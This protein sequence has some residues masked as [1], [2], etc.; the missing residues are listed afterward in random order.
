MANTS[1][2]RA[3]KDKNYTV[4]DNTCLRD[5]TLSW[6]ARGIMAYL[7]SLPEDW[8]IY[9]SEVET[10]ATDGRDSLMSGIKELREHGYIVV[11][12][13]R[14]KDGTFENIRYNVIENPNY[15]QTGFPY[16]DKPE[17]VKPVTDNPQLLN[18]DSYQLLNIQNT[19]SIS[20]KSDDKK[21]VPSK[22]EKTDNTTYADIE[23]AYTTAF[24]ELFPDGKCVINYGAARKRIKSLLSTLSEDDII[25]AINKAKSDKW[26][27][28][29]MGFGIMTILSDNQI[30]K[31]LNGNSS[32]PKPAYNNHELSKAQEEYLL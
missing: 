2:Y 10:H 24:S 13:T 9:L 23:S 22:P 5:K 19:D 15:P 18:T 31:L 26:I 25:S 30:Q 29:D 7:L 1:F 6:K 17:M 20:R 21:N 14:N 16:T 28:R 8:D 27:A 12:K 4:L 32:V 3:K 11:T